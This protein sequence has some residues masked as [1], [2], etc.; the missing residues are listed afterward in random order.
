MGVSTSGASGFAPSLTGGVAG[1]D[2]KPEPAFSTDLPKTMPSFTPGVSPIVIPDVKPDTAP[3]II[4]RIDEIVVP[5]QRQ[6]V[7]PDSG[8]PLIPDQP[9]K[10]TPSYPTP[11]LQ[12]GKATFGL[13]PN[14]FKLEEGGYGL[15]SELR[16]TGLRSKKKVYPISTAAEMIG[17]GGKQKRAKKAKK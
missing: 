10:I 2:V 12:K 4:P 17:L 13:P 16:F 15:P 14:G 11:Y 1:F 3:I 8:Q 7:I 6:P 5:D 9:Q